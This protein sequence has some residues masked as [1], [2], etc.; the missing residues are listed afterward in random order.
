MS[1]PEDV[2]A[3][4][5]GQEAPAQEGPQ[6]APQAPQEAQRRQGIAWND[7]TFCVGY[8]GSGKSELLNHLFSAQRCQRVLV[9]TKDEFSIE[10]VEPVHDAGD[11]DWSAPLIHFS[12]EAGDLDDFDRLFRACYARRNLSMCVHELADLCEDQPGAAPRWVRA[13]LRKGRAH[14]LGLLGGTQRP[15]GMPR[16]SRTE[17]QH[18]FA[19][20]PR[21][22]PDDLP[23]VARM[24]HLAPAELEGALRSAHAAHGDHAFLWYDVPAAQL[25]VCPPLPARARAQTIVSRRTVA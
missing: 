18:I 22:D 25:T 9:D 19:F 15:V 3:A 12:S 8:T 23:V 7:R 16:V 24:M 14:G 4:E 10:G 11:I 20:A 21:L 13:Y 6:A 1:G 2:T 17:A 5:P